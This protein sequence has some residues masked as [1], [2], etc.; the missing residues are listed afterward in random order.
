MDILNNLF[1]KFSLADNAFYLVQKPK[2]SPTLHN[3]QNA[4]LAP[5]RQ[6]EITFGCQVRCLLLPHN[7]PT[8]CASN[9]PH[10]KRP[11]GLF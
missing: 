4:A 7:R 2:A 6:M 11:F 8:G 9:L 1:G 5:S 3:S 10:K